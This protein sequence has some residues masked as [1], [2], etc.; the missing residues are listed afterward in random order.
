MKISKFFLPLIISTT[1]LFSCTKDNLSTSLPNGKTIGGSGEE[2]GS[3][4]IEA[5]DGGY[6][7]LGS[8]T[9]NSN[10]K[11]DILLKKT[12]ENGNVEW[13][14]NIGG[15]GADGGKSIKKTNDNGYIIIG[16]TRSYSDKNNGD[17]YL[18]K[19]DKFGNTQWYKTFGGQ[20][21]DNGYYV[22]QTADNGFV[23]LGYTNYVGTA[24][25][26]MYLIKTD[27][28]GNEVWNKTFGTT[29]FRIGY[30]LKQT[31][32]KG[33]III[34][35]K[36]EYYDSKNRDMYVIKTD[37]LGNEIWSKTFGDNNFDSGRD[38]VIDENESF[39]FLGGT[40]SHGN[41]DVYLLKTDK[42]GNLLWS[43]TYGGTNADD[44]EAICKTNENGYAITGMT[45][46]YG[47]KFPGDLYFLKVDSN[48]N[49]ISEKTN[50]DKKQQKGESILQNKKG[51]FVILGTSW[52]WGKRTDKDMFLVIDK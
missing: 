19:T 28:E 34:G 38:V 31:K 13:T 30:S 32:D 3:D 20:N 49:K 21:Y 15:I 9:T 33:F 18:V 25:C 14:K 50:G 12:D 51:Q 40:S 24:P 29:D 36:A 45:Y 42:D 2:E 26:N 37:S 16:G 52:G 11:Y 39:V 48:G 35:E 8:T 43:K 10:G 6:I 27:S 23:L 7:L 5:I 22:E 47:K 17:I 46:S 1:I 44:G 4:I 41:G